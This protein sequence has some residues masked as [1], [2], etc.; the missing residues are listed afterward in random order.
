[1]FPWQARSGQAAAGL[2][3]AGCRLPRGAP[4]A[5]LAF[6]VR[7]SES[8]LGPNVSLQHDTD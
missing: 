3:A 4:P 1:M 2:G 7:K 5:V 6:A 8:G